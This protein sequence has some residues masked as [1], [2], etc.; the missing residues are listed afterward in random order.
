MAM[1]NLLRDRLT[2][3]K[4]D[5]R[6]FDNVAASVQNNFVCTDDLKLP[7]EEGDIF[8]RN[9]P[10]GLQETYEVTDTGY[11]EGKGSIASHYQSKV[12][13][14]LSANRK[15]SKATMLKLFVSHSC[16]D[17]EIVTLLVDLLKTALNLSASEIRCTSIDGYRLPGGANTVEQLR[18]EVHD[19]QAFIGII[20]P[21]SLESMY[22]A[23]ELGARW[24]AG[25]HLLPVLAPGT[26]ASILL[27]PLKGINALRC[28]NAA[29]LHQLIND[30]SNV[31]DAKSDT[32]SV[33]QRHVDK[34]LAYCQS[35]G[36]RDSSE[37]AGN[38][39]S[40]SESAA[41]SDFEFRILLAVAKLERATV[42]QVASAMQVGREKAKFYLDELSRKHELL[43]WYASMDRSRPDSYMLTHKGRGLLV[44]RGAIE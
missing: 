24:G 5:G 16:K 1:R 13:K 19:A 26:D 2:L 38:P 8:Q 6:R 42:D 41:I 28:D 15:E 22:V 20:S 10:N 9:L 3:V 30:V 29:Q 25:K 18:R 14:V 11:V 32:P 33:L 44:E 35:S 7:L 40:I 27:G 12:R 36:S 37:N 23:F 17:N 21:S 39:E 31:L 34:I 43:D 4:A